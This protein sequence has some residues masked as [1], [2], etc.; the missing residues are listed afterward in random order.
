MAKIE[1]RMTKGLDFM[2]L[3]LFEGVRGPPA[4]GR[5]GARRD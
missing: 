3:L 4:A 1:G 2:V 5:G